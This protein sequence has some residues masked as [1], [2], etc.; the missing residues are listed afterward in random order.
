[1]IVPRGDI[2]SKVASLL[3]KLMH[4]RRAKEPLVDVEEK[5]ANAVVENDSLSPL[6][7]ENQQDSA[8]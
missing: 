4:S 6:A 3:D 5:G 1:M 2:P 7:S 8:N